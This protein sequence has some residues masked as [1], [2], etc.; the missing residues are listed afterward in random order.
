[1]KGLTEFIANSALDSNLPFEMIVAPEGKDWKGQ[2]T[3]EVGRFKIPVF[4]ELLQ[5]EQ[6]FFEVLGSK[7]SNR[8]LEFQMQITQ[9]RQ[10]IKQHFGLPTH[11]E[12]SQVFSYFLG[13]LNGAK[14]EEFETKYIAL[15]SDFDE[16]ASDKQADF[17]KLLE[18]AQT[19]A[20]DRVLNW[21]QV[22]FFLRSRCDENFD[23]ADVARLLPSQFDAVLKLIRL[24]ANNGIEPVAPTADGESEGN[25]KQPTLAPGEPSTSNSKPADSET[26]GS[27]TDDLVLTA[28]A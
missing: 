9:M 14:L 17:A 11:Q 21:F 28:V 13:S 15:L 4:N 19:T 16:F 23:I 5:R 22:A 12:A 8:Q 27:T 24:E 18:M 7:S 3:K 6:W 20:G 26:T 25:E 2:P 1:M 10:M